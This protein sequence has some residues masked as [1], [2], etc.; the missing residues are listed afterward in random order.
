MTPASPPGVAADLPYGIVV[1][2]GVAEAVGHGEDSGP[3]LW[4][5]RRD[6][7]DAPVVRGDLDQVTCRDP[8]PREVIRVEEG[9]IVGATPMQLLDVPT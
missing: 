3:Q 9:G 2:R 6:A 1:F 8:E 4:R 7:Q 5:R